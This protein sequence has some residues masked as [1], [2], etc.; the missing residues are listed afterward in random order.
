M[1][2]TPPTIEE[3]FVSSA[4]TTADKTPS[5]QMSH[6]QKVLSGRRDENEPGK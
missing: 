6:V 5:E 4:A 3:E 2:E 1:R